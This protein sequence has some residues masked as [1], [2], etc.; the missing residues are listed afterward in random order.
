MKRSTEE[1]LVTG[2]ACWCLRETGLSL[3]RVDG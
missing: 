3:S 2:K 1:R